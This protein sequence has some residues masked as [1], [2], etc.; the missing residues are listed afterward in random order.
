MAAVTVG[1]LDAAAVCKAL[2]SE[3]AS[4]VRPGRKGLCGPDVERMREM[5]WRKRVS[6]WGTKNGL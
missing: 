2:R 1:S 6:K 3:R 5:V 4:W